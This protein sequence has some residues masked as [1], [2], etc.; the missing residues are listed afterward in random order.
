MQDWCQNNAMELNF[1]KCNQVIITRNQAN[2][3]SELPVKTVEESTILGVTIN[4]KLNWNSHVTNLKKRANQCFHALRRLKQFLSPGELHVVYTTH[5]RSVL[6]YACPVFVGLN[7]VTNDTL[8]KVD[9]RAH[10]IIFGDN[11]RS[12]ACL[13]LQERRNKLSMKLFSKISINSNHLL[14]KHIPKR[15]RT[16]RNLYKNFYCRTQKYSDSFFPFL[17]RLSNSLNSSD[18]S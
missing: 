5:I 9:N 7:K 18:Q 1:R 14:H 10:R 17:T 13:S 3:C 2:S 15:L 12:C 11:P 4:G 16:K 8:Q 6:E